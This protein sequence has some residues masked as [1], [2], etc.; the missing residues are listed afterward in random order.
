MLSAGD[1]A[2]RLTIRQALE[3]QFARRGLPMTIVSLSLC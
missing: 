2:T 3:R 1:G